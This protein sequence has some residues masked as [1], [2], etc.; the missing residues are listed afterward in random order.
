[1]KGP[2]WGCQGDCMAGVGNDLCSSPY[3]CSSE[4]GSGTQH[5]DIIC[6]SKLGTEF[7]VT[8]PSNC[9]H[10]PRP[11]A[12]QPCQGQACQDRWFSTPWSPVSAWLP[13]PA[14]PESPVKWGLLSLH[15][16]VSLN[17]KISP[18]EVSH[19]PISFGLGGQVGPIHLGFCS[20]P[21]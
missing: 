19:C 10:L 17:R 11:P 7:N 15:P 21:R 14:Q 16:P 1:M 12:L 3:Q 18:A 6:V 8:S 4:C 5:R 9:S 20:V 13:C 2:R